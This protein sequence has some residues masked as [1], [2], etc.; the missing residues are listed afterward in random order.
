VEEVVLE[1]EEAAFGDEVEGVAVECRKVREAD[2]RTLW[3]DDLGE[4]VGDGQARTSA[5]SRKLDYSDLKGDQVF[6]YLLTTRRAKRWRCR[7]DWRIAGPRTGPAF[8]PSEDVDGPS[9][10]SAGLL[11][12]L[13]LLLLDE[14]RDDFDLPA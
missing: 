3:N 5:M 1:A 13:L 10:Q 12:W 11:L 7:D 14:G 6:F 2:L 8:P 4:R 9:Q